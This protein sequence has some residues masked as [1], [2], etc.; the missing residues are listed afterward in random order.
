MEYERGYRVN[1]DDDTVETFMGLDLSDDDEKRYQVD[2]WMYRYGWVE[3]NSKFFQTE[4]GAIA[5]VERRIQKHGGRYRIVDL[6]TVQPVREMEPK[7][8]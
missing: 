7:E 4:I 6:G 1:P 2:R 3:D 5:Y 8:A